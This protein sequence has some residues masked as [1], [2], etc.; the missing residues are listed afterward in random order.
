MVFVL[1]V[2]CHEGSGGG[3]G[4]KVKDLGWGGI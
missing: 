3:G 1:D 2:S 4:G